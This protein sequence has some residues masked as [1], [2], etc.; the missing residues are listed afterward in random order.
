[1]AS[2]ERMRLINISMSVLVVINEKKI[3]YLLSSPF[4]QTIDF[5][6][7]DPRDGKLEIFKFCL[8]KIELSEKLFNP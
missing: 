3:I 6:H 5:L 4:R 2:S 1:M 7:H 8:K